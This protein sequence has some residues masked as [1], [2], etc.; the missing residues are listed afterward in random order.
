MA[1]FSRVVRDTSYGHL[2]GKH[3]HNY[4]NFFQLPLLNTSTILLFQRS[5]VSLQIVKIII[6]SPNT[7]NFQ[8]TYGQQVE[9]NMLQSF[10]FLFQMNSHPFT[11]PN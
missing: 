10:L 6:R 9:Q 3:R 1:S 11:F 2:S 4:N 7:H 5:M 8:S